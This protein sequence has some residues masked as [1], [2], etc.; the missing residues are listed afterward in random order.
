MNNLHLEVDKLN[1]E[2]KNLN[3][4][5][6]QVKSRKEENLK[7]DG[8]MKELEIKENQLSND[9]TR[10]NTARDIAM[11]N[12]TEEKN[13]HTKLIEQL[14]QIKQQ[15]ALNQTVFD[16]QEN[17][18][19]QSNQELVQLKEEYA[20]KQELLSTLSTGFHRLGMSLLGISPN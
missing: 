4:D 15:L 7:T 19:K 9:L 8:S 17:E 20:N 10:L 6:D 3:E 13:K 14:E 12:L 11:D 16:N 2:I 1:H 18:Y 5:L